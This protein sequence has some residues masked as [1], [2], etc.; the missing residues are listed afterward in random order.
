[1]RVCATR[2]GR[3]EKAREASN[4]L[5]AAHPSELNAIRYTLCSSANRERAA[6]I[7]F[8]GLF[9]ACVPLTPLPSG[10]LHLCTYGTRTQSGA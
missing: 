4:S 2:C 3:S 9:L 5:R 7:R 6:S 1:M 8:H 10:E